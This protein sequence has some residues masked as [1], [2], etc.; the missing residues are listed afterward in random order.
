MEKT[1]AE[2]LAQAILALADGQPLGAE[3]TAQVQA[4]VRGIDFD[5]LERE[6]I[7]AV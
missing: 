3:L 7:E 2:V 5:A 6:G 4:I 1:K